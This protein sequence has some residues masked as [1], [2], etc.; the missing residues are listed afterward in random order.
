MN[1]RELC[2]WRPGLDA[3]CRHHGVTRS[4]VETGLYRLG[5]NW[6]DR[7][8]YIS[9]EDE[10]LEVRNGKLAARGHVLKRHSA[11]KASAKTTRAQPAVGAVKANG[12]ATTKT[13]KRTTWNSPPLSCATEEISD[14][15]ITASHIWTSAAINASTATER[16]IWIND[17]AICASDVWTNDLVKTSIAAV[18]PAIVSSIDKLISDSKAS[19]TTGTCDPAIGAANASTTSDL[20]ASLKMHVESVKLLGKWQTAEE[21]EIVLEQQELAQWQ[22]VDRTSV[23]FYCEEPEVVMETIVPPDNDGSHK[24]DFCGYS[25]VVTNRYPAGVCLEEHTM[26]N[27]KVDWM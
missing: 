6:L 22:L 2:V 5:F 18:S 11:I 13:L 20:D 8:H 25:M 10:V 24:C 17:T 19:T 16:A 14:A 26:E 21:L 12:D 3:Y 15:A 23:P 7:S 4:S 9:A 27:F 1:M